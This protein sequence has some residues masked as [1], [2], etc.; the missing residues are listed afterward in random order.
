[1][2]ALMFLL[3]LGGGIWLAIAISKSANKRQQARRQ[4]ALP[5]WQHAVQTCET[6]YGLRRLMT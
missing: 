1:M 4:L 3:I 5:R 6:P 2:G